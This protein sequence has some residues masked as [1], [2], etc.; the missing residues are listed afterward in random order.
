[1]GCFGYA[2]L[3]NLADPLVVKMMHKILYK[4]IPV[5]PGMFCHLSKLGGCTLTSTNQ[6][7]IIISIFRYRIPAPGERR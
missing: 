4:N 5:F 1:M 2:Q 6:Y 3:S 7:N